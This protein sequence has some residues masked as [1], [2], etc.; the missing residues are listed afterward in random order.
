MVPTKPVLSIWFIQPSTYFYHTVRFTTIYHFN[1]YIYIMTSHVSHHKR[2]VLICGFQLSIRLSHWVIS[3]TTNAMIDPFITL[4]PIP[5]W[6]IWS[7]SLEDGSLV[8]KQQVFFFWIALFRYN[9]R[10]VVNLE[11]KYPIPCN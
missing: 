11:K 9:G 5:L 8:T 2:H 1:I 7:Y 6:E 4:W 10:T 3:E